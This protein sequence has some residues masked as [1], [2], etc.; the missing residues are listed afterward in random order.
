MVLDILLIF[1]LIILGVGVWALCF[2]GLMFLVYKI[3]YHSPMF[4]KKD[5]KCEHDD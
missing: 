3:Y 2:V 4:I 1:L 5:G